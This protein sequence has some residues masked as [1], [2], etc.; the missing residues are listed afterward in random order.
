[1]SVQGIVVSENI[2]T[3]YLHT[4]MNQHNLVK[5]SHLMIKRLMMLSS[6]NYEKIGDH[7]EKHMLAGMGHS[8]GTVVLRNVCI[9]AKGHAVRYCRRFAFLKEKCGM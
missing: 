4:L 3:L 2:L 8:H 9:P 6:G 7:Y 5:E 1:M